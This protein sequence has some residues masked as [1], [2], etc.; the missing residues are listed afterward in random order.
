MHR[1][2]CCMTQPLALLAKELQLPRLA[3]VKVPVLH[4]Q[5]EHSLLFDAL[6]Q[7]NRGSS[8]VCFCELP[9]F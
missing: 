7:W 9:S 6:D 8:Q 2:E 3:H 5:A 4:I 1:H